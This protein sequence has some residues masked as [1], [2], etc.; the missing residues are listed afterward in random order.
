M[1]Q[2]KELVLVREKGLVQEWAT[3][4]VRERGRAMVL[5][6]VRGLAQERVLALEMGMVRNLSFH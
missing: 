6:G 4:M 5:V 1:V 2:G 3:V